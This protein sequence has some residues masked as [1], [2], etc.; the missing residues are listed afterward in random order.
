MQWTSNK[1][2]LQLLCSWCYTLQIGV[3]A[4]R[5]TEQKSKNPSTCQSCIWCEFGLAELLTVRGAREASRGRSHCGTRKTNHMLPLSLHWF[6]SLMFSIRD[7]RN[8]ADTWRLIAKLALDAS[9]FSEKN[10]PNYLHRDKPEGRCQ[11]L[12]QEAWVYVAVQN[13]RSL[14]TWNPNSNMGWQAVQTHPPKSHQS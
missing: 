10:H 11:S 9:S 6:F 8:C 14:D 7:K 12:K 4:A 2:K 13:N 1:R 5:W 3:E